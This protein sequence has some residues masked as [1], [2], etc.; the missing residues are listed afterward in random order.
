MA[1]HQSCGG[2]NG[3]AR[4]WFSFVCQAGFWMLRG[5]D[6]TEDGWLSP[7]C[8]EFASSG[9][10]EE[11]ASSCFS[12]Q[13]LSCKHLRRRGCIGAA[14][15]SDS[16]FSICVLTMHSHVCYVSD[17]KQGNMLPLTSLGTCSLIVRRWPNVPSSGML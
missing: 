5:A 13:E 12:P 7:S 8:F 14:V 10:W 9:L 6:V 17:M 16:S 3:T 15:Q 1:C 4:A 2:G 11:S